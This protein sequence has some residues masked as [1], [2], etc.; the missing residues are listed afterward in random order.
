MVNEPTSTEQ[1]SDKYADL[2]SDV[3]SLIH[4]A[5]LQASL[6]V[7]REL[8]ILYW[9]IGQ[10]IL[11]RQQAE[12]WGAK[13]IDRLAQDLRHT[14][15][16][17]TGLSSRNIKYMRAFADAWPDPSIVQQLVARLPWGHNLRLLERL[18]STEERTWYAR[19]VIEHG[20]SRD[21]LVH[22]IDTDL[23][24]RQGSALTNFTQTLPPIQSELAQQIIEDPYSFEF[25]PMGADLR[26]RDLEKG[27]IAHLQSL[28]LE[29]GKGFAFVGTQ[30]PLNVGGQD[31]YLD[32]LFYHLR[33]RC[34]VAMELLCSPAH[35]K[36]IC[37][38]SWTTALSIY[39]IRRRYCHWRTFSYR[40]T[41]DPKIAETHRPRD[42]CHLYESGWWSGVCRSD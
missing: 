26:E 42:N 38:N 15:P 4:G 28:I 31:Y 22:Q 35:N 11:T 34:F 3:K 29:L 14:F 16:D 1:P 2:L 9:H 13:V 10:D 36:S 8:V 27:L 6:A 33:L 21:V 20:W 24:S 39:R 18:K 7:N 32:L 5:R 17:M 12:G 41:S 25:L 23:F 19:Q 30:Y 37:S 40:W